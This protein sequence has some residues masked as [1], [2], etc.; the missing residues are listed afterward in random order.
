MVS[1]DVKSLFTSVP[2]DVACDIVRKRLEAEM[3]KADS[4]VRAQT[5]MDVDDI[6]IL[7]RLCLNTTYFQVN[8]K[9]Y[10]QKQGTA[11][12]SPV[13]V[14]IANMF[15]EELEQKSLE[16]FGHSVKVWKRY[17]DDTFVVVKKEHVEAL[18]QHLNDQFT[19]VSFTLEE[20]KE[21]SLAFL[22]VEVKRCQDGSVK[23]AVFRKV[24]HTDKYL[25]FNSHH[26][27]QHKESV[28]RSLVQRGDLYPSDDTDKSSERKHIDQTLRANNYPKRFIR[29]TCR[30]IQ[31]RSNGAGHRQE[32]ERKPMVVLPYIQ[33]V[34]ERIT[35]ILAPTC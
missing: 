31:A 16:T 3:E 24:T 27:V 11:M 21:G 1:F 23:T 14:V 7:L 20:E 32:G 6:M 2:T 12:G 28:I 29:R 25:D 26:S 19:G 18:H 13:S 34:T 9:F 8:G 15:M 30:K 33:G 17:V 35:R 22:D 5:A 10:K 4:S